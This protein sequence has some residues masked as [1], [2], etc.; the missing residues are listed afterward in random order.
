MPK[1]PPAPNL[2][3]LLPSW[4]LSLRADRKS[5]TTL[6]TYSDGVRSERDDPA[7]A[8]LAPAD[9][10][11]AG[12]GV[13]VGSLEGDDLASACPGLHHQAKDRLIPA[14][15]QHLGRGASLRRGASLEQRA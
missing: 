14:V 6:K 1:K 11:G 8:T 3:L 4:Q 9:D 5:E 7:L 10:R 15:A 12:R 2:D 13:D